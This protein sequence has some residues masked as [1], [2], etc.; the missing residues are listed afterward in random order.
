MIK[1]S[2]GTMTYSGQKMEDKQG[3]MMSTT[4]GK[5]SF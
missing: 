5:V 1:E 4:R 2:E 3:D